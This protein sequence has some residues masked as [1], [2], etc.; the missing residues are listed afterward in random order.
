MQPE[1]ARVMMRRR[2][3][4][5][6]SGVEADVDRLR[7]GRSGPRVP[8]QPAG[9]DGRTDEVGGCPARTGNLPRLA[10]SPAASRSRVRRLTPDKLDQVMSAPL[11]TT[12]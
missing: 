7:A 2:A 5:A 1:P 11:L 8:L 12:L 9:P 3:A 4:G 10:A 6:V